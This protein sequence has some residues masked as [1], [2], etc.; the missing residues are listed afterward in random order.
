[1]NTCD[2]CLGHG[3]IIRFSDGSLIRCPKCFGSSTPAP[4]A[5]TRPP[6]EIPSSETEDGNAGHTLPGQQSLPP[7]RR[8][9]TKPAGEIKPRESCAGPSDSHGSSPIPVGTNLRY[10]QIPV[11]T[12]L[13]AVASS[14][15]HFLSVAQ[16]SRETF[17]VSDFD[18]S[19]K[20][21]GILPPNE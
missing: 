12:D 7:T 17:L 16:M 1:M 6:A 5:A 3:K 8:D 9:K 18:S 20:S 14:E 2:M 4:P 10:P 15:P 13:Q 11:G 21:S 19:N